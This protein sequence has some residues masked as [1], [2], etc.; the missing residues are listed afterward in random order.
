MSNRWLKYGMVGL[1]AL[2]MATSLYLGYARY[3]VEKDNKQVE[4]ALEWGQVQSLAQKENVGVEE[5]LERL[6]PAA[7]GIVF[8]ESTV[9][10]LRSQNKIL[11]KTGAELSWDLKIATG[12]SLLPVQNKNAAV[13]HLEWNYLIFSDADEFAR[14][15]RN[16]DIKTGAQEKEFV[17]YYL[18]TK[19]GALPVLGTSLSLKEVCETGVG[20]DQD[21]LQLA[22]EHGYH[23]IPQ[24]RYWRDVNNQSLDLVFHQFQGLPVSAVFFNDRDLPGVGLLGE[25]QTEAFKMLAQRITAMNVPI[26]MIEFFPQKGLSSTARFGEKNLVRLHAIAENEMPAMTQTRA[27]DR[28]T[29]AVT[30]RDIR[31]L[32]VRF[33][34]DMNLHDTVS[35]FQELKSSISGEGFSLGSPRPFSSLPFSRIY[36]FLISLA[37]AAGGVLL[38]SHLGY[39]AAGAVLGILGVLGFGGLMFTGQVALARKGLALISVIVFP[40]LSVAVNLGERP[41]SIIKSLGLLIRTT[42]LSLIGALLMVGLLADKS[43]MYT[44]DQFMGVKLAHLVPIVL[45]LL[46]FWLIRDRK[47]VLKKILAVLNSPVTVKY[48]CLLGV[49]GVILLVYVLRT[50]NENAVVSS[51]ELALR[52]K[53]ENLLAVRP[54]TKE[55]LIGHPLMLLMFYLGYRDRYLPILLVAVIGQVSVVNTFAHIHTPLAI[56]LLRTFNGMWLGMIIGLCLIGAYLLAV[57]MMR[58]LKLK[59]D[60]PGS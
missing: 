9:N 59:M 57:R 20:F 56:S 39:P 32:L 37:V 15:Y 17:S 5:V 21:A 24:I 44:L 1:I 48:L 27:V 45:I 52:A 51:W 31:V 19:E 40:T 34:P 12:E 30:D 46:I 8:K 14:V 6:K 35:Y 29:L 49:L 4:V 58:Y 54:R 25:R 13:V 28:F 47:N 3:Q 60:L 10:D 2:G 22:A 42:L 11:L 7:S 23:I 41:A 38:F 50:G 43:F 55:F 33:F 36:L 18:Q 26:G 16:L 53:L